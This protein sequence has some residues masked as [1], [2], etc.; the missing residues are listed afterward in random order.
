ML[1]LSLLLSLLLCPKNKKKIPSVN[2]RPIH[3]I[4]LWDSWWQFMCFCCA[5]ALS[6]LC[7][8]IRYFSA[9]LLPLPKLW[10]GVL[11]WLLFCTFV[12]VSRHHIINVNGQIVRQD[13]SSVRPT[14]GIKWFDFRQLCSRKSPSLSRLTTIKYQ[15]TSW[16]VNFYRKKPSSNV[17]H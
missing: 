4:L 7:Q 10:E 6:V 1:L 5:P 17:C 11:L 14:A 9:Q 8:K 2:P 16:T 13:A 3:C 12:L 15:M